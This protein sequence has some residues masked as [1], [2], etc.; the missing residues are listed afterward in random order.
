V[1]STGVRSR[2]W[3]WP[4]LLSLD[5]PIVAVLWQALFARC[6]HADVNLLAAV[7]LVLAVWLIYVLDRVFDAWSGSSLLPRHE[8]YL[9]YWRTV[10][11]VWIGVL[12]VAG[13]LA[14]T[15]LPL[16]LLER[17]L[18]LLAAVGIYL[19]AV[20]IAPVTWPKEAAVAVMFAAGASLSA[21]GNVRSAVD[22]ATIVLFSCLCWI[23]CVAI[24][25]WERHVARWPI[26]MAALG[27]GVAAILVWSQHRPVL[28]AA[29]AASA[30]AFVL[31]DCGRNRFSR[32][33]LR[34]LADVALLSP[35]FFLPLARTLA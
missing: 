9:R 21:W 35:V 3:L 4:N 20:H 1:L 6:F 22:L 29:E 13:W 23:N 28:G 2:P 26:A 10:M 11:P 16:L 8:F 25:Q 7:L 33:A 31:L 15:R 17:G 30:L 34:V 12:G 27:V 32:D 14:W 5:A 24:E 18:I 19:A